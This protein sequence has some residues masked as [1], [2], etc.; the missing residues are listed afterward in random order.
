MV[1]VHA[2]G[3]S[4]MMTAAQEALLNHSHK[5]LLIAVTVL[6]SMQQ[7]D[8]AEL[9]WDM[10]PIDRV[11]HLA[12]L[13]AASRLDGVVCSAAEAAVL[14][15][16]HQKGFYLVTP[17][18]RLAGDDVGDQRR[19][20]TPEAAVSAGATHLVIGRSIT[21]AA[22]PAGKVE[23]IQASVNSIADQSNSGASPDLS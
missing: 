5:P 8:L 14:S 17:G 18:I 22:D 19:V 7:E 3:G 12:A 15:E 1:N 21:D 16:R 20:V 4:R 6:T 13:A 11:S 9:G 10:S 23:E 2:T